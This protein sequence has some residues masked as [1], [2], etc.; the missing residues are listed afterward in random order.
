MRINGGMLMIIGIAAAGIIYISIAMWRHNKRARE[1][2][3][4]LIRD[5]LPLNELMAQ[6]FDVQERFEQLVQWGEIAAVRWAWADTKC[7]PERPY[8]F[9]RAGITVDR[10][11]DEDANDDPTYP[12]E[13]GILYGR[14]KNEDIVVERHYY[15]KEKF[16]IRFRVLHQGVREHIYYNTIH[17]TIEYERIVFDEFERYVFWEKLSQGGL[18]RE[19]YTWDGERLVSIEAS[20]AAWEKDQLAA[21]KTTIKYQS[22]YSDTGRMKGL[23]IADARNGESSYLNLQEQQS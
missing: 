6:Y 1:F 15:E 16:H 19:S 23:K 5:F 9:E 7:Y 17:N 18:E 20:E 13:N 14:N 3:S 2:T 22:D 4:L 8:E 21:P 10:L 12:Y 11:P